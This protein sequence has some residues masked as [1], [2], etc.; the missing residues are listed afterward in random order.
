[1]AASAALCGPQHWGSGY[2][3]L[4]ALETHGSSKWLVVYEGPLRAKDSVWIPRWV[5]RA[6]DFSSVGSAGL[7]IGNFWTAGVSRDYL[8]LV[9]Q[10]GNTVTLKV[11]QPPDYFKVGSWTLRSTSTVTLTSGTVIAAAAGNPLGR[12]VAGTLLDN[13]V[14]QILLLVQDGSTLRVVMLTPPGSPTGTTWT[15]AKNVA[16][17]AITGDYRGFACGDFWNENKDV[18]AVA[19]VTGGATAIAFYQFNTSSSTFSLITTDAAADL[20]AIALNG[21]VAAD[22]CR[23]G[24]DVLTLIPPEPNGTFQLRAAP[25]KPGQTYNPGA[26]YNGKAMS[27]QWLPGNGGAASRV[28]MTGT[29][30]TQSTANTAFTAGRVFGYVNKD[31]GAQLS[32]S[33]SPDAEIA[34]TH[35]TPL[36]SL[37]AGAPHWGWPFK[38][39]PVTYEINLKNNGQS[40]IPGGSATVKV[41]IN[42]PCR[43][44]DTNP[45]TC[46]NPDYVFTVTDPLPPFDPNNPSYIK[47]N[48]STTWP[49]DLIAA[50]PGATRKKVNLD[51]VGER[52]LVV[53]MDCA[54]DTNLRN[55]RYEAAFHGMTYHPLFRYN[56]TLADREP[57]V[58]G[59]PCSIEYLARKMADGILCVY[60]RS[61]TTN[62]EDA[63]QRPYMD[64][65]G[66][67]FP[68]D[69]PDPAQREAA[70]RAVQEW[71]E[72]W[73]ELDLW[74]GQG[75]NWERFDWTYAAELHESGHLFSP[76][77]DLY[78]LYIMPVW[79]GAAKM[80]DGTPVQ[81][82]THA[83][84]ADLFSSGEAIVNPAEAESTRQNLAGIRQGAEIG[85]WQYAPDRVF[86]RVLDRDGSPVA[87]AQVT[88][89]QYWAA[90][91]DAT[92]TTGADGRWEVSSLL[93]YLNTDALGHK[94]YSGFTSALSAILT[95][96]IGSYQDACIMGADDT[97]GFS[98][99]GRLTAL[100]NAFA[101]R[102]EWTYDIKTNYKAVAPEPSFE[103]ETA[104]QGTTVQ[105]GISAVPGRIY[106][107]YRRF[108]P[109]Y[110]R[111]FIGEYS[112]PGTTLSITQ[113]MAAADSRSSGRFR[114]IYEVTEVVGGV[115]SLPRTAQLTGLKNALGVS[116]TSGGEMIVAANAGIANP[117]AILFRDAAPYVEYFYH[118]RFGHTAIK[119]AQSRLD[120]AR[121]YA[122][123]TGSDTDPAYGFDLITPSA[124]QAGGYDVRNE[125]G[126]FTAVQ[127]STASPYWI[128]L[129]SAQTA[130]AIKPN[131]Y[132]S[133]GS[134]SSFV[135]QV[136]GDTIY[137]SS[138]IFPSGLSNPVFAAL[139][140]AGRAGTRANMRELSNPRG[141]ATILHAG[142]EYVV[143]ADT[144][145]RR[146]V[147]WDDGTGYVTHWQSS[148]TLA[149]VAAIAPHPFSSDKFYALVRR[150][151]KQ[152]KLYLFTF[153]GAVLSIDAGYPVSLSVGD[154]GYGTEMGLAAA[155][156]AATGALV[157]AV[158]DAVAKK[159]FEFK[160]VGGSW[161]QFAA[162]TQ[163]IGTYAGSTSL[164]Q[165]IDAAYAAD[166]QGL[167]LYA[168]DRTGQDAYGVG[169][170]R[171]VC[172]AD[173]PFPA[174]PIMQAKALADGTL[175]SLSGIVSAVLPNDAP[176]K[177]YTEDPGRSC[178]IQ[179]RYEGTA[180]TLGRAVTTIGI[181]GTD[182][183]NHE[184]YVQMPQWSQSGEEAPVAP[185]AV[186]TVSLGGAAAGRQEGASDGRG[187][188]NIGLL[189]RMFGRV[190]AIVP[191][192]SYVYLSDGSGVADGSGPA[193]VRVDLSAIAPGSRPGTLVGNKVTATGISS[194]YQQ[195]TGYHRMIRVRSAEDFRDMSAVDWKTIQG[196]VSE[197][198]SY[199]HIGTDGT[200]LYVVFA[201]QQ[202]YRYSFPAGDPTSGTWTRLANP[203]RNVYA[204]N[205]FSDLAYQN[206]YLY[207]SAAANTGGRTVLRYRIADP[208]WEVW[209]NGGVDI[210]VCATT[211]NG[212]FMH[213][214][215]A[216]VGYS[217]SVTAGAWVQF[218]WDAKSANNAWMSTSGLAVPDAGY[219]SRNE[220]VAT[221]GSGVYYGT[222]NDK[223]AGLSGG[224]VIYTWTG[225]V[226]PTPAVLAQ[227]PWQAGFG[228]SAEFVPAVASPTGH[229]ELWLLRG[230][231]GS[232]NPGD[233]LGSATDDYAR[234]DLADVGAGWL[235]GHLPG[236]AGYTGELVLVDGCIFV[237][238][239]GA[240]WYVA[241]LQ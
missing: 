127:Y 232:S 61:G 158:T 182:P 89:W 28:V 138:C 7:V 197:W 214:A 87:G 174:T 48:A 124:G 224:D 175:V 66:I 2:P 139:R 147:V 73:R 198:T 76:L 167:N 116:A 53:T 38:D 171:L 18:F 177:C 125:M 5:D 17:P 21:L 233:G 223:T 72:G 166:T 68:D 130:S 146:V 36:Y 74:W 240:S 122:V 3:Y 67:G 40:T 209:Q 82:F 215:Q 205:S 97:L 119:I 30:Q 156:D 56:S 29:F 237:R 227:K 23:D 140:T 160:Y 16:L 26:Y 51:A 31:I 161:Q 154:S 47:L 193:G 58:D 218:D 4:A 85:W 204:S 9:T 170:M 169:I 22:Y 208:T 143:I 112:T 172:L 129:D 83:W 90:T 188:N 6:T 20:P 35:R 128:E 178:G 157:V 8:V 105:L 184:R 33:S 57:T 241:A 162:Y 239:Q 212:I 37:F 71:Y 135:T 13:G 134:S 60:E 126:N 106:R 101:N 19:T 142:V 86:L 221:N 80:A 10:A 145:N 222:K 189:V 81:M 219:V 104:V 226:S 49:Y 25:A 155:A 98:S 114:A 69:Y 203:P 110:I 52:W 195:G 78:G 115:E 230:A 24:F 141:V 216:G 55:N 14:D 181:M 229:D 228:Q 192:Q 159:V 201:N 94:H 173:R 63:L 75:Q 59:D 176:P 103:L 231:D 95:V 225:L 186:T 107:L 180:P 123:L 137:T 84:G 213:G 42:T 62:N 236:L 117:F 121:Y 113:D 165:P 91:A 70:W 102:S 64:S 210:N 235:T 11:L 111:T 151:D 39:E 207:T 12:T 1:M 179:A 153:D 196:P 118:F 34:F 220:D 88:I 120:P 211:G 54:G 163:P 234:L 93:T 32:Y 43:N 194:L 131:D 50:G 148:D 200:S 183:A 187:L 149:K 164:V 136:S 168:L 45:A 109:A 133:Y 190:T 92:G 238:G 99:S 65:Y 217:A 41:W 46:D 96:R 144:G 27:R 202:L 44:A 191:D 199:N 206:G 77:G 185:L 100:Y 150:T 152:S 132:V 79:T 15:I 108:E